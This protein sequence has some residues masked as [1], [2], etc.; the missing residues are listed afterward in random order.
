MYETR[1]DSPVEMNSIV[2]STVGKINKVT[3]EGVLKEKEEEIRISHKNWVLC[4]CQ[5]KYYHIDSSS[6]HQVIGI[7]SEKS[8]ILKTPMEVVHVAIDMMEIVFWSIKVLSAGRCSFK[9]ASHNARIV[10]VQGNV[11]PIV[12]IALISS[13]RTLDPKSTTNYPLYSSVEMLCIM[14]IWY[15]NKDTVYSS[16]CT[17]IWWFSCQSFQSHQFFSCLWILARSIFW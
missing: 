7:L 3:A 1:G 4:G 6:S 2:K 5:G 11:M 8:S 9:F 15:R 14:W 17:G 12:N 16:A 13:L 10:S